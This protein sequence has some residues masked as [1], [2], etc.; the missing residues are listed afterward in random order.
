MGFN[1]KAN[2]ELN[3]GCP[4]QTWIVIMVGFP[5][6]IFAFVMYCQFCRLP[7]DK[8]TNSEE[9]K[10]AGA[11]EISSPRNLVKICKT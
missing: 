9:E 2:A 4:M 6:L 1:L 7:K 11:Q 5:Y 10:N 3:G 8:E